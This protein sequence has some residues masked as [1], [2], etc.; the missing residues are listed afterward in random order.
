MTFCYHALNSINSRTITWFCSY[1][2]DA[3][4]V[5][6]NVPTYDLARGA[7]R[8]QASQWLNHRDRQTFHFPIKVIGLMSECTYV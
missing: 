8:A 3:T 1:C 7:E 5:C 4:A 6:Q 2:D